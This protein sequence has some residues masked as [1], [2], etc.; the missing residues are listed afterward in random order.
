MAHIELSAVSDEHG[1][2]ISENGFNVTLRKTE[3][4]KKE[5]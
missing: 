2:K 3:D 1:K 5:K 4:K